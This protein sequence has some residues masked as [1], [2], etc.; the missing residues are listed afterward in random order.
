MEKDHDLRMMEVMMIRR[1]A[2]AVHN[3]MEEKKSVTF[4][5]SGLLKMLSMNGTER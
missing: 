3:L 2:F 4:D 5:P 1:K